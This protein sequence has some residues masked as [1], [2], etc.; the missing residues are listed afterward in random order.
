MRNPIAKSL[1]SRHLAQR[2]VTPKKGKGSFK[3][4]ARTAR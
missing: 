4:K 1:R 3:R 2:I